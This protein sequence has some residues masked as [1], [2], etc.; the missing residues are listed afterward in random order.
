[1]GKLLEILQENLD[2]MRMELT[3]WRGMYSQSVKDLNSEY[4]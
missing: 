1:M 3:M 4:G 2:T